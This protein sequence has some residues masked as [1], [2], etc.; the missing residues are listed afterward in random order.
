MNQVALP[1]AM[2]SRHLP[3]LQTGHARADRRAPHFEVSE[4]GR[5]ADSHAVTCPVCRQAT[6]VPTE[7]P[8]YF[9]VSGS[10][11]CADSHAVCRQATL[12]PT[13]GPHLFFPG[14]CDESPTLMNNIE[15]I[16]IQLWHGDC[17]GHANASRANYIDLDLH[18]RPHT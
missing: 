13:E 5:C 11:R 15:V 1:T 14:E 17:L 10:G 2:P 16:I 9:E 7:G 6:P 18:S 12:V 8:P 3:R 4:S